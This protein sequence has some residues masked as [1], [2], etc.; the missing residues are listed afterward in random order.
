A[1]HRRS[2]PRRQAQRRDDQMTSLRRRAFATLMLVAAAVPA[3]AQERA[4]QMPA[5]RSL[6]VVAGG[7]TVVQTPFPITRFA[8]SNPAIADAT[9]VEPRQ[10]LVD[11]KATGTS[12]LIVWGADSSLSKYDVIVHAPTPA[13]QREYKN[14]F[15]A[16]EINV[17]VA[18]EA[19]V[20]HGTVSSNQI[21]LRAV[22]IAEKS[23]S[24]S[25]VIN[26][27]QLP[28]GSNENQQV[29]L[30]VRIAEVDQRALLE[31]GSTL[32]MGPNKNFVGLSS[33]QQFNT[34]NFEG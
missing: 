29:M 11:G 27:L 21:A 17:S 14:L 15:P 26:M 4:A 10:L 1:L 18:D 6:L 23:S 31:L 32:F 3:A 20:L 9:I 22:E 5:V 30:Q 13:L 25:K 19:I 28:G 7:S 24:K 33:T 2:H 8:I 12:S 16:E 34:T